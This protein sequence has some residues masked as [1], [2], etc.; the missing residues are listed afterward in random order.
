MA[1]LSWPHDRCCSRR[2]GRCF[3]TSTSRRTQGPHPG[4]GKPGRL[5]R[6]R[7]DPGVLSN[8]LHGLSTAPAADLGRGS[9]DCRACATTTDRCSTRQPP[10]VTGGCSPPPSP[11]CAPSAYHATGSAQWITF[12]VMMIV[13]WSA[14]A[15][16]LGF[17]VR[18]L[19]G[20]P[21][22]VGFAI[23]HL[24]FGWLIR[25]SSLINVVPFRAGCC[26]PPCRTPCSCWTAAT[27]SS[28]ATTPGT[29]WPGA[30]CRADCRWREWPV[31]GSPR[32]ER[33]KAEPRDEARP[34]ARGRCAPIRPLV[35]DSPVSSEMVRARDSPGAPTGL[36]TARRDRA[37]PAAVETHRR[38]RPNAT[39]S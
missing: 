10:G 4:A 6:R 3:C 25:S 19:G 35:L 13:P 17:G 26:S 14:N 39:I 7:A 11:S 1:L 38:A 31:F 23:A 15:A 36:S 2:C 34:A 12:L 33:L 22:P 29:V 18:L 32:A 30:T 37:P 24:G 28:T 21:T 8:G 9:W 16:Y 5:R 27:A 20:D